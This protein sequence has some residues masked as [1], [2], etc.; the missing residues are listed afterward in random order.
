MKIIVIVL[1]D[2]VIDVLNR[3]GRAS[4]WGARH[5]LRLQG[6]YEMEHSAKSFSG[7]RL[8][9]ITPEHWSLI[10]QA[11]DIVQVR[12]RPWY[13]MYAAAHRLPDG[14][15]SELSQDQLRALIAAGTKVEVEEER[16]DICV[17]ST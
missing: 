17:I 8:Y 10:Q 6:C 13:L 16:S 11:L 15:I 4:A 12:G 2:D 9:G 5:V 3:E 14:M 1:I 7:M